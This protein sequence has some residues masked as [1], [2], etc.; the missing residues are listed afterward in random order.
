MLHND[1]LTQ[2]AILDHKKTNSPCTG[3]NRIIGLNNV[4]SAFTSIRLILTIIDNEK[5][6]WC[7]EFF[8]NSWFQTKNKE[9]T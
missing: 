2:S 1:H 8:E 7:L 4:K 5:S 3:I 9:L 6:L